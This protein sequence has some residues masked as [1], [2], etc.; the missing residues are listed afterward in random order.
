MIGSTL[1]LIFAQSYHSPVPLEIL[2]ARTPSD[3]VHRC[4]SA[5]WHR[6]AIYLKACGLGLL[7]GEALPW[8]G[9]IHHSALEKLIILGANIRLK[10][11]DTG[12]RAANAPTSKG[13]AKT[14]LG[15]SGPLQCAAKPYLIYSLPP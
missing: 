7:C 8:A 6:I 11:G 2:G 10:S 3:P 13:P 1:I 9:F 14:S 5:G 12:R 4:L 15:I